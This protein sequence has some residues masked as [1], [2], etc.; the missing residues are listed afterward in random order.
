MP[1]ALEDIEP[2][3]DSPFNGLFEY[4]I[5]FDPAQFLPGLDGGNMA[6]Q[7]QCFQ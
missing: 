2:G 4:F 1:H 7:A 6:E 3:P 5:S